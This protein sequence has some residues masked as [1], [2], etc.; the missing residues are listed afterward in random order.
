MKS[1]E[2]HQKNK[3]PIVE[4]DE[5]FTYVKK[6]QIKSEYG[7]LLIETGYVLLGLRSGMQAPKPSE[8]YGTE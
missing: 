8:S 2:T 3:I 5:L 6:K 7:L 4:L 1:T